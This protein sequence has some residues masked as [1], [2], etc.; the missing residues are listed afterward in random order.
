MTRAAL[1]DYLHAH[2]ETDVRGALSGGWG[3]LQFYG[4]GYH[5]MF[6]KPARVIPET[7]YVAIGASFLNGSVS[8]FRPD[9]QGNLVSEE[10]RIN[11]LAAYRARIPEA[12]FGNAIFL[13][14]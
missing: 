8:P 7:R 10:E 13:I 5:E 14:A 3:T 6:P 11:Y 9:E 4:I 1:A 2:G 12:T